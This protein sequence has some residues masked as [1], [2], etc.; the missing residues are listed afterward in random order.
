MPGRQ[1]LSAYALSVKAQQAG[2]EIGK[3]PDGGSKGMTFIALV[4]QCPLSSDSPH[5][6]F[7]FS[8]ASA[9]APFVGLQSVAPFRSR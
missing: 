2:E 7:D 3:Q 8:T 4:S 6:F 5:L 9:V 1:R